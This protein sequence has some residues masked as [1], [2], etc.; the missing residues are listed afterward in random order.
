MGLNMNSGITPK[1]QSRIQKYTQEKDDKNEL[2]KEF[3]KLENKFKN[4]K[5][6]LEDNLNKS[7]S[8]EK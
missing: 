7:K 8:K 1:R 6:E 2:M 4:K 3:L 5:T